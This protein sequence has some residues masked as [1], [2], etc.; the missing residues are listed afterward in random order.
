MFRGGV[1]AASRNTSTG[2]RRASARASHA[3]GGSRRSGERGRVSGSPRGEA[4]RLRL[5]ASPHR[6]ADTESGL[7]RSG[8][9]EAAGEI[10]PFRMRIA[11]DVQKGGR[12]HT[13]YVG[14]VID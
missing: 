12:L 5:E 13:R 14:N 10:E 4:S 1:Q 2:Q 8:R 9:T 3:P 11:N 7:D 6:E